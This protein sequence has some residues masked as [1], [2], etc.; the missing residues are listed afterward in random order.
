MTPHPRVAPRRSV[1]N[2]MAH[3]VDAAPAQPHRF[4]LEVFLGY[5]YVLSSLCLSFY[6]LQL[7]ALHLANDARLTNFN[8]S[9]AQSFLIDA[10]NRELEHPRLDVSIWN[11]TSTSIAKDYSTPNTPL[12]I[13]AGYARR[14]LL[15]DTRIEAV[16]R[17]SLQ[18]SANTLS[19]LPTQY[20]WVDFRRRWGLA[21]TRRRQERCVER[22][23]D[24][25]AVYLESTLRLA[26][27][28]DW[29][30]FHGGGFVPAIVSGMTPRENGQLWLGQVAATIVTDADMESAVWRLHNLTRYAL[31]WQNYQQD[32]LVEY[33]AVSNG[34]GKH[35]IEVK[36]M[37]YS[38]RM[39]VPWSTWTG[40][41][42]AWNDWASAAALASKFNVT[43]V[44]SGN[45]TS[46]VQAL[47]FE[48]AVGVPSQL[49]SASAMLI[50][51]V[52]GPF[53]S[54]DMR[55]VALPAA[56]VAYYATFPSPTGGAAIGSLASTSAELD[57]IPSLWTSQPTIF[58]GGSSLCADSPP[59]FQWSFGFDRSCGTNLDN[60]VPLDTSNTLFALFSTR[61][62]NV[63][64]LCRQ[65]QGTKFTCQS[66]F[67]AAMASFQAI[68]AS[69]SFHRVS[70]L[71]QA[72]VASMAFVGLVQLAR[73]PLSSTMLL[74]R[75]PIVTGN[76]T[77]DVFGWAMVHDWLRGHR[78]V[79]TLEGDVS[80][81]TLMSSYYA[82]ISFDA[83]P[84]DVPANTGKALA[85]TMMYVSVVLAGLAL[86]LA[87]YS[88]MNRWSVI[89]RNLFRF[90]RV[91][92]CV[93]IGRP[94]LLAR[95][96]SAILLL[97]RDTLDLQA[98][99]GVGTLFVSKRR[100][101]VDSMVVVGEASWA[102]FVVHDLM[103][104]GSSHVYAYGPLGN[105]VAWAVLVCTDIV[106][107]YKVSAD[108][109]RECVATVEGQACTVGTIHL[110]SVC[111]VNVW[112]R[113]RQNPVAPRPTATLL[114]PSSVEAFLDVPLQMNACSQTMDTMTCVLAGLFPLAKEGHTFLF[115]VKSWRFVP[116]EMIAHLIHV[117]SPTFTPVNATHADHT[118]TNAINNVH[119]VPDVVAHERGPTTKQR[120]RTFKVGVSV[121]YMIGTVATSMT[122]VQYANESIGND[123]FWIGFNSSG[124]H[125][126]L[127][128][129]FTS[130]LLV[131]DDAANLLSLDFV[132][133]M[134]YNQSGVV[135]PHPPMY[136]TWVQQ[137]IGYNLTKVIH[138]LRLLTTDDALWLST[139][140]C[141]LDFRQRSWH[142]TA[143]EPYDWLDAFEVAFAS[144]LRSTH[145]GRIFWA[146]IQ[147][148]TSIVEEARV[149]T[150]EGVE[151][152][153]TQWQNYKTIGITESFM[154]QNAFG[155][156]YPLS[157]KASNGT[158]RLAY[159]TSMKLYWSLSMDLIYVVV[160][161]SFGNGSSLLRQSPA[162][163]YRNVTVSTAMQR[164][165]MTLTTPYHSAVVCGIL[166]PFGSIDAKIETPGIARQWALKGY[167]SWEAGALRVEGGDILCASGTP[168]PVIITGGMMASFG[169]T[170]GCLARAS[171][172]QIDSAA[173]VFALTAW[174]SRHP[175]RPLNTTYV[176]SGRGTARDCA[177]TLT[178]VAAGVRSTRSLQNLSSA[179]AHTNISALEIAQIQFVVSPQ[180]VRRSVQVAFFTQPQ[181]EFFAWCLIYDWVLGFR[182]V[183]KFEGD[184]GA[185]TS[186][187]ARYPTTSWQPQASEIPRNVVNFLRM[188][189]VYVTSVIAF[190]A[191]LVI[192]YTALGRGHIEP[193]NV[194]HVNRVAGFV[195]IGRPLLF[196]RSMVPLGILSTSKA[197]LVRHG[198]LNM[199]QMPQPDAL[200]FVRAVLSSSEACWLVFVIQD[201]LTIATQDRAQRHA[202]RASVFVWGVSALC[203]CLYPV[204]PTV[205]LE[206]RCNFDVV[207]VQLECHSGSIAIGS[208]HRFYLLVV[209]TVG[210]VVGSVLV[211]LGCNRT[212]KVSGPSLHHVNGGTTT[213]LFLCNGA[214]NLFRN[215][216]FWTL[217]NVYYLDLAS[218]V[219]NG[220]LVVWWRDG[221][222]YV[223]DFKTW[224]SFTIERP[225]FRP[226]DHVPDH[227]QH[228]FPLI[229]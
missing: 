128:N 82:P 84:N 122:F 132:D 194:F 54:I 139:Q 31:Q 35:L 203:S 120:L 119:A 78:E 80:S 223:L 34:F 178:Q 134:L 13:P 64:H 25:A 70:D 86:I 143:I 14:A 97:S 218:A 65:C 156:V 50:R 59:I 3:P 153:T 186:M 29:V 94:L 162:F 51:R 88:V 151:F 40:Y 212:S 60:T 149:W 205:T 2:D 155:A 77:W 220:L 68:N 173:L 183:V 47:D 225:Q 167:E 154:V 56:L 187:S 111:V 180:N 52:L 108:I 209:F 179:A 164:T 208:V 96:I 92:G 177:A 117:H 224:R 1:Y 102:V 174:Q 61:V 215:Q 115:D 204:A 57:P 210:S 127:A 140:Y 63:S 125:T 124:T 49:I 11:I 87:V 33:V 18:A 36:H 221:K 37:E 147:D 4:Y 114:L 145:S 141:W 101:W 45:S 9:G 5:G 213:S 16:I 27:W 189:V 26:N 130:H 90:N 116:C 176:C 165:S 10:I 98:I 228:S 6:Y 202:S 48:F 182:D 214:R 136:A 121:L 38:M 184:R 113:L 28:D 199:I 192:M 109:S 222:M 196:T 103:L 53:L 66:H 198:H 106:A 191:G 44:T 161:S 118:S 91:A 123:F 217:D 110:A 100:H 150:N 107:P 30:A 142:S 200:H 157:L 216:P 227:F 55:H 175:S 185:M 219:M 83:G 41:W 46:S 137:E 67:E 105:M 188:G 163:A 197:C 20:C 169:I 131:Q 73:R 201:L 126:F 170:H 129:W 76:S 144:E 148:H 211:Q 206:Q 43:L 39:D 104:L 93:W 75:H 19:R 12:L 195:W 181:F 15:D 112:N 207:D 171:M 81:L 62:Q 17:R 32:G 193:R 22:D 42:G 21:H 71:R 69:S 160:N 135:I 138:G 133:T 72:A 7:L 85:F 95:G 23:S 158:Y 159:Q 226:Q 229:E 166:G 79:V 89:G 190:V 146:S 74:L 172:L 168:L 58:Y 152:F 99:R 24:N 8:Q